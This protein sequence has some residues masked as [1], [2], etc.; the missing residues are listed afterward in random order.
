MSYGRILQPT[1]YVDTPNWQMSRG[2]AS[3]AYSVKIGVDL[4]DHDSEFVDAELFDMK[5]N[6]Q[7]TFSTT[8][9]T[10][11]HVLIVIDTQETTQRKHFVAILNHNMKS[12]TAKFRIASETSPITAADPNALGCSEIM[13]ADDN[14][15]IFTPDRNGTSMVIINSE[16]QDRYIA[17]QIEGSDGSN[18]SGTEDLKIGCVMVGEY[19][20]MP[21]APDL[22]VKRSIEFGT[23]LQTSIGGNEYSNARWLENLSTTE[24]SGQPFR[25]EGSGDVGATR[26]NRMGGRMSYDLSFSYMA[27]S[28]ILLEDMSNSSP[29][30]DTFISDVWLRT[31]GSHIPF[32][33][34]PDSTSST[35]GDYLFAR[36]DQNKL[37]MTQVANQTW[38]IKMRVKETW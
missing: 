30:E 18:F 17:I 8:G 31:G 24:T 34:T 23:N 13:N 38:N 37:D 1:F 21:H 15:D 9:D 7:V 26:W 32:I 20:T 22:S 3:S 28:N 36:F 29:S 12:A 16:D 10:D 6:N 5:P 19:F 33:F 2:V 25:M 14:S 11:G 27:D 35:I 4:I